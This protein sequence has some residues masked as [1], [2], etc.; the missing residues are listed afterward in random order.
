MATAVDTSLLVAA[1]LS[2]HENHEVARS[3]FDH[4]R[5]EGLL[6]PGPA[7]I[8][9]YSVMTRLPAPHRL[10]PADAH[11]LIS[12]NLRGSSIIYLTGK[13]LWKLVGQLVD[14]TIAGGR[15]YDAHIMACAR[16]A[17]ATRLLT[18]NAR[19]FASLAEDVE[20]PTLI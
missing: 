14:S 20:V 19:H 17:R 15:A 5:A 4:A 3:A 12:K 1:M 18:L 8:E 10:S 6:L 11:D 13:E 7:L 16:K 2:W 9:A